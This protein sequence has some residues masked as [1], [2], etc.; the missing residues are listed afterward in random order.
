M[1]GH[2]PGHAVATSSAVLKQH[3]TTTEPLSLAALLLAPPL[4]LLAAP[5]VAATSLSTTFSVPSAKL[6]PPAP[7]LDTFRPYFFSL[8]RST[9]VV[10]VVV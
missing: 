7:S 5:V 9:P 1:A 4:A 2:T 6:E 10:L 8:A 3:F